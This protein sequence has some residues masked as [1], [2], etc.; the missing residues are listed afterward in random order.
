MSPYIRSKGE[1]DAVH[2]DDNLLDHSAEGIGLA[3][4][5]DVYIN[6][7]MF[8]LHVHDSILTAKVQDFERNMLN[9]SSI[10]NGEVQPM[11]AQIDELSMLF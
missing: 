1:T 6:G 10:K 5:G 2:A 3:G 8:I 4:S 7:M 11:R 9:L